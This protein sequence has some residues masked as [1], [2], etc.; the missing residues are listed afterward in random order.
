[1]TRQAG[2]VLRLR[3]KAAFVPHLPFAG[4]DLVV[5]GGVRLQIAEADAVVPG[6]AAFVLSA[7]SLDASAF[8]PDVTGSI[9]VRLPGDGGRVAVGVRVGCADDVDSIRQILFAGCI[10]GRMFDRVLR[11]RPWSQ[12]TYRDEQ[13]KCLT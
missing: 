7:V 6:T 8:Q 3:C 1:M 13:H 2:L 5:V 12:G 9:L 4:A 11:Q 10:G